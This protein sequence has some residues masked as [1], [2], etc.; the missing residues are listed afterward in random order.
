MSEKWESDSLRWI[1]ELR[2]KNYRQV[3]GKPLR[4][5][6]VGPSREAQ[7]LIRKLGLKRT[8]LRPEESLAPKRQARSR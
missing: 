7:A 2:E 8:P 6:P 4:E 1:H 3:K 5:F